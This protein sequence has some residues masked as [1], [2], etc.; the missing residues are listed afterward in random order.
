MA[1]LSSG[2]HKAL[3]ILPDAAKFPLL[4]RELL[5]AQLRPLYGR[6]PDAKIST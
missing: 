3:E 6:A 2:V 5:T 4:P 1:E